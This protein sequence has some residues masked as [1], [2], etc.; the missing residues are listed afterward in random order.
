MEVDYT[1]KLT[2]SCIFIFQFCGFC[3]CF[4]S[5]YEV[6]CALCCPIV[7]LRKKNVWLVKGPFRGGNTKSAKKSRDNSGNVAHR[8]YPMTSPIGRGEADP[9][10]ERGQAGV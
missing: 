2:L 1:L 9:G 6:A 3:C 8:P 4:H 7:A 5:F 10:K